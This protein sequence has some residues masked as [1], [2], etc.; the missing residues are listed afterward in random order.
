MIWQ[1]FPEADAITNHHE[2]HQVHTL[3]QIAPDCSDQLFKL[4][5]DLM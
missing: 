1:I 2:S 5:R 3:H 4:D